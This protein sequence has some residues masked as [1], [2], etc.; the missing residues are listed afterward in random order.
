MVNLNHRKGKEKFTRGK[1]CGKLQKWQLTVFS[2]AGILQGTI[3]Q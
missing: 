1:I 3:Q 2:M